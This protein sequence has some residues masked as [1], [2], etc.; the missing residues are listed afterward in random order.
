MNRFC[1]LAPLLLAGCA[2]PSEAAHS[3]DTLINQ[4]E[5]AHAKLIA[6]REHD[7]QSAIDWNHHVLG[8]P[9]SGWFAI[10]AACVVL[11][12]ILLICIGVAVYN[13]REDAAKK[14][15]SLRVEELRLRLAA[16]ERGSCPVC[17]H[18]WVGDEDSATEVMKELK[19]LS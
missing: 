18:S 16:I 3:N 15:H 12:F 14:R 1:L 4:N 7:I 10:T 19:K 2:T 9:S 6:D 5:D 8:I 17:Q 11:G 13:A